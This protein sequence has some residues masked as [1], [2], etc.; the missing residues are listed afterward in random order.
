MS[1]RR[2][3]SRSRH[4]Y[5]QR[6]NWFFRLLVARYVLRIVIGVGVAYLAIN[7]INRMISTMH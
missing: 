7:G 5:N 4:Q 6:P 1:R 3:R 2:S